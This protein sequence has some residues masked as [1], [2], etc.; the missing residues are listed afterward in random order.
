MAPK[1]A[2]DSDRQVE[3]AADQA[4]TYRN[5]ED[6]NENR[7]VDDVDVIADAYETGDRDR[8]RGE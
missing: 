8:E 4:V 1:P 5:G 3:V 6:A 7:V 2:I